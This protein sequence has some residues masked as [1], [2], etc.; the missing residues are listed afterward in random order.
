M[1]INYVYNFYGFLR[2]GAN[3]AL[4]HQRGNPLLASMRNLTQ[5]DGENTRFF[6]S[7]IG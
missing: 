4:P 5:I 6:F 1:V 3:T 2:D 7:N